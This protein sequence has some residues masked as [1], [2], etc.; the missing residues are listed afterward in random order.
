MINWSKATVIDKELDREV[1]QEGHVHPQGRCTIH[2]L[3]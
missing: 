3:Q 1:E 2:E